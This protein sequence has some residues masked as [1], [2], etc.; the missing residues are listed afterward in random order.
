MIQ[1]IYLLSSKKISFHL[2][3]LFFLPF[4]WYKFSLF[5]L[6]FHSF[7][8]GVF[9]KSSLVYLEAFQVKGLR[10]QPQ[11][12]HNKEREGERQGETERDRERD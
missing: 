11:S 3:S 7:F 5:L 1:L 10:L 2:Y 12:T 9:N 4:F 6:L 8:S